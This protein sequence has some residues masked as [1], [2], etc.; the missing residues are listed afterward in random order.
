MII[1]KEGF[2]EKL[3]EIEEMIAQ[4]IDFFAEQSFDDAEMMTRRASGKLV[5]IVLKDL[6]NPISILRDRELE[7]LIEETR[8]SIEKIAIQ[9][10]TT[11]IQKEE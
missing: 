8:R 7:D 1:K 11:L 2:R 4:A 3:E 10:K 9:T 5:G 6:D